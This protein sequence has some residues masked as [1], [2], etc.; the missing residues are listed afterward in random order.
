MSL[1]LGRSSGS[2]NEKKRMRHPLEEKQQMQAQRSLAASLSKNEMRAAGR[3][4]AAY[5]QSYS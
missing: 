3:T 1:L 2:E 5:N 4:T